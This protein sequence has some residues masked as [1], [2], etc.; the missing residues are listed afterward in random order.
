M[1]QLMRR[2]PFRPTLRFC[3]SYF[4]KRGFLDGRAG[5]IFCRLLASYEMLNVFKAHEIRL[6][7]RRERNR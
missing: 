3:Y 7:L 2:L 1:R 6:K 5:Y 4:W